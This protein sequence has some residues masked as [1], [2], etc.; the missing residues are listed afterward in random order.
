MISD[1]AGTHGRGAVR[2]GA[3]SRPGVLFFGV[4]RDNI[5]LEPFEVPKPPD[6][7]DVCQRFDSLPQMGSTFCP[8]LRCPYEQIWDATMIP[9]L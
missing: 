9:I 4:M 8:L 5:Y 7:C 2:T 1:W 3:A 6:V